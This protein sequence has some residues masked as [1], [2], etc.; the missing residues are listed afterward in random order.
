MAYKIKELRMVLINIFRE[1]KKDM[2][3]S[4]NKDQTIQK[5][6]EIGVQFKVRKKIEFNKYRIF[7]EIPRRNKTENQN[8]SELIERSVGKLHQ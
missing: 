4:Q 6:N 3:K 5:L 2:N 8:F 1:P 7:E